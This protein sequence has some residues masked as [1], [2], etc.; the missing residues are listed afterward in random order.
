M[1]AQWRKAFAGMVESRSP[2]AATLRTSWQYYNI[3]LGFTATPYLK[4]DDISAK[5]LNALPFPVFS[6]IRGFGAQ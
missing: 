6:T 4:L 5:V 1:F 3:S 2:F